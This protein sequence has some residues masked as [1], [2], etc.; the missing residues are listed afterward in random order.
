MVSTVQCRVYAFT[1]Q[2]FETLETLSVERG[3]LPLTDAIKQLIAA[4]DH[5]VSGVRTDTSGWM[6]PIRGICC[7]CHG[8]S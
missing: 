4:D 2:I 8:N 6:Q 5:G 3:E 7:R 1:Q